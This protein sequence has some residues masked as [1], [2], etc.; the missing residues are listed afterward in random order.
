[1]KNASSAAFDAVK[2]AASKTWHVVSNPVE[3]LGKV[4]D[5]MKWAGEKAFDGI[6]AAGGAAWKFIQNP[7]EKINGG[8]DF[9]LGKGR[10]YG[11]AA[12]SFFGFENLFGTGENP[13]QKEGTPVPKAL[14]NSQEAKVA[15]GGVI[16]Q[17]QKATTT[18]KTTSQDNVTHIGVQNVYFETCQ[19]FMK[20]MENLVLGTA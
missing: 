16:K 3:S 15:E 19:D 20:C 18:N 2:T 17:V 7:Y 11:N 9:V 5:G 1:M 4:W 10:E 13:G 12:G 8:L 14:E 6:K